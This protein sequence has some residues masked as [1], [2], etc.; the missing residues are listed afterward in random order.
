MDVSGWKVATH[1]GHYKYIDWQTEKSAL[2]M[3][4]KRFLLPPLWDHFC[5]SLSHTLT[6]THFPQN[7]HTHHCSFKLQ[8]RL[9][10][11]A[12]EC[13][14]RT[15]STVYRALLS[16]H[17][18][19]QWLHWGWAQVKAYLKGLFNTEKRG[20]IPEPQGRGGWGEGEGFTAGSSTSTPALSSKRR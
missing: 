12:S 20:C 2:Y 8:P 13:E 9:G 11:M 16:T 3:T 5:P 6:V 17:P 10:R 19:P 1:P 4:W 15:S 7:S 18:F 14:K